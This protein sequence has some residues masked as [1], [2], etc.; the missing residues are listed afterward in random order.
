MS[1]Q[2]AAPDFRRM[3]EVA[4]LGEREERVVLTATPEE[5]AALAK[6]TGVQ[7][8]EALEAEA[9]VRAANGGGARA[10][11][12]FHADVIQSSVVTLE[13]VQSRIDEAF[14]VEF[15]PRGDADEAKESEDDFSL[16]AFGDIE[17]SE[18][19]GEV[20]DGWFDL[21]DM[22]AQYLSLAIDP[23]PRHP[24]EE[25]GEWDDTPDKG[26]GKKAGPF[27]ALKNWRSRA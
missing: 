19:P 15:Q 22:I 7:S 2:Q 17:A 1:S 20:V 18:P 13:P 4:T 6:R 3:I 10:R 27:A 5:R 23:Y 21:G 14:E 25:F 24:G 26:E 9:F 12:T 16:E 11:V 8:V